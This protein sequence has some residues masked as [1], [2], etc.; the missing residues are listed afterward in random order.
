[1]LNSIQKKLSAETDSKL[2]SLQRGVGSEHLQMVTWPLV[3][4]FTTHNE[5]VLQTSHGD[6]VVLA[7]NE[8]GSR[9]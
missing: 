9:A 3:S 5:E 2:A 7:W 8:V 1:M 4:Q 6:P